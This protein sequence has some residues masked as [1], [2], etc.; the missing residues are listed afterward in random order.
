MVAHASIQDV[1]FLFHHSSPGKETGGWILDRSRTP[2]HLC[3]DDGGF[4]VVPVLCCLSL[5]RAG[6]RLIRLILA[7]MV[8]VNGVFGSGRT[9][10]SFFPSFLFQSIPKRSPIEPTLRS[11]RNRQDSLLSAIEPI[12]L[13]RPPIPT[14][15]RPLPLRVQPFLASSQRSNFGPFPLRIALPRTSPIPSWMSLPATPKKSNR[16]PKKKDEKKKT[17][18]SK[19]KRDEGRRRACRTRAS[20]ASLRS[21]SDVETRSRVVK[22]R[23]E[24]VEGRAAV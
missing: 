23:L 4:P 18:E 5:S 8:H 14:P 16:K 22:E 15:D 10:L 19:V 1:C 13:E 2:S 9:C 24:H 12:E 21:R 20:R 7:A 3:I 17:N 11:F 6:R